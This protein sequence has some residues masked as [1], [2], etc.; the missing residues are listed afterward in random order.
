MAV[1]ARRRAC[2]VSSEFTLPIQPT[3]VLHMRRVA[4]GWLVWLL[5]RPNTAH[6]T[7]VYLRDDSTVQ[8]VTEGPGGDLHIIDIKLLGDNT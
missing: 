6:H 5:G 3:R 8:R 1:E 4:D 2:C 7:Y